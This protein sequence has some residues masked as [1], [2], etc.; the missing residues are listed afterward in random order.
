MGHDAKSGIQHANLSREAVD[1]DRGAPATLRTRMMIRA[2][3]LTIPPSRPAMPVSRNT[4]AT[5]KWIA[6][7][8]EE[9]SLGCLHRSVGTPWVEAETM[10]SSHDQS[11]SVR[12]RTKA[13]T[14]A[15]HRKFNFDD[16]E[17]AGAQTE[18]LITSTLG[19]HL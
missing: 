5:E 7:W 19:A 17:F 4:G 18:H 11:L 14:R 10:I 1:D 16:G 15:S 8:D 13:S 2:K 3:P 6:C 12:R 9:R